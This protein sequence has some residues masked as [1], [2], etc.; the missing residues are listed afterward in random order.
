MCGIFGFNFEDKSFCKKGLKTMTPRGPDDSGVYVD[1]KVTLGHNRLSII[2]LSKYGK[3]PLSNENET[4]LITFN[5]EIYN[6]KELKNHLK[7]NHNFKS[8]TDTELLVHLYEEEG[9]NMLDKLQ[10]MFAFCI[11]DKIKN[12][13]FLN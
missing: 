6:F 7:K 9:I 13:F 2:D 4:I 10:G 5:G 1:K 12:I 11:Y 8:N 3:Q